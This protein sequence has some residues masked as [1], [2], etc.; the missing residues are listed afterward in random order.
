MSCAP[1]L[2]PATAACPVPQLELRAPSSGLDLLLPSNS[3][4]ASPVDISAMLT[5]CTVS[6]YSQR[7]D[8]CVLRYCDRYATAGLT[9]WHTSN[10]VLVNKQSQNTS[11]E[12]F[13]KLDP[14]N[15]GYTGL[16]T[17]DT[18]NVGYKGLRTLDTYSC[19]NN[20]II[21]NIAIDMS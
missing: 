17:L 15:V 19:M 11:C 4:A 14:G 2:R 1:R 20:W 12:I 5:N 10:H 9:C 13:K 21:K 16:R 6:L 7:I 8:A 18:E 3:T